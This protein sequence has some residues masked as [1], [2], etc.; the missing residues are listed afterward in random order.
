MQTTIDTTTF[1]SVQP[2][3]MGYAQ[4]AVR[5]HELARDLVQET[6]LA[7]ARHLGSFDGRASFRTWMVGILKHK[8]ID[9]F[10]R[11]DRELGVD[12]EV[13]SEP[14][15]DVHLDWARALGVVREELNRLPD[16]QRRAVELCDVQGVSR[17]EAA[18]RLGVERGHLRVLLHRGRNRLR[19]SLQA[20]GVSL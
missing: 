10:R 18:Q 6:W 9:H 15:N 4:R 19:E 8:I 13:V 12:V 7:G 5:Q 16:L 20:A 17:D 1:S 3:L 14:Q 11:A 2:V